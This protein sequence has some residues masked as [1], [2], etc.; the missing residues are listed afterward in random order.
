MFPNK[1]LKIFATLA[2]CAGFTTLFLV[3]TDNLEIPEPLSAQ[4]EEEVFTKPLPTPV[5]SEKVE[6]EPLP[7][8]AHFLNMGA[9]EPL[10]DVLLQEYAWGG[11]DNVSGLQTVLGVVVDGQYGYQTRNAHL[12]FLEGVGWDDGSVP[13]V[14]DVPAV[15]APS[16]RCAQWWATARAAGWK[17]EHLPKLDRI[18]FSESRCTPDIISRTNDFGLTQINWAAH[19]DRLSDA[20]ITRDMLLDPYINLVQAKWIADYA[21]SNF[22]CWSQ[23]WYMSGSWC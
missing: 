3:P 11:G 23:P 22:G 1:P 9:L 14:P 12:E 15:T 16:P 4:V 18:M 6:E 21:A 19:G 13:D 2:V 17:E 5:V 8:T 7:T 10:T 20:G